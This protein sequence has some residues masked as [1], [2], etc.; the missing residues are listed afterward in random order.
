MKNKII[1][2]IVAVAMLFVMPITASAAAPEIGLESSY[3]AETGLVTVSVYATNA[4]GLQSADLN[5]GFSEDMYE[6]SEYTSAEVSDC[7]IVGG[8]I[9]GTPG[10]CTC[11][12]IFTE[13][14]VEEN[15][16]DNGRLNLATYTFKPVNDEYDINEFCLWASSF[17]VNGVNIVKTVKAV[18][19]TS[20]Q[21][22]KTEEVTLKKTDKPVEG[23]QDNTTKK[24]GTANTSKEINSKWYVYLIAGVLA[25]GAIA[26]IAFVAIKSSHNN[27]ETE[28]NEKSENKEDSEDSEEK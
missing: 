18:G 22:D 21:E 28:N 3:N 8:Y 17:D 13:Q 16:D 14:C 2:L 6:F 7:M 15:L 19:N 23:G 27:E 5:L 26:G 4:V 10:L 25:V 11:S 1:F 24:G 12:V 9:E 20:L